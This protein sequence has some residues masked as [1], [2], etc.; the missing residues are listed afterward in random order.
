MSP[1]TI[2]RV[3]NIFAVL[4]LE[5][6]VHHKKIGG[7]EHTVQTDETVIVKGRLHT[8]PSSMYD[9]M[10]NT[11]WLVG[12]ID[13][14]TREM[15]LE[16]VSYRSGQT[17]KNYFIRNIKPE[18]LCLTDG[19][20]S[21]PGA[22]DGIRGDHHV[23]IHED[24]FKNDAGETTNLIEGVWA[25]LKYEIK[26]K[27]GIKRCTIPDALEEFKWRR[28]CVKKYNSNCIRTQFIY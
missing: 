22:V 15:I 10:C 25:L 7:F 26:V 14:D 12:S 20:K 3:K 23:L 24:G 8:N 6:E 5:N 21:Y 1:S 18:T 13:A 27:K 2:L 9:S 16:I 17:M 11:T 4:T 28:R 19:H